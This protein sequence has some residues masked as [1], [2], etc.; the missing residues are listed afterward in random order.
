M[1]DVTIAVLRGEAEAD[2]EWKDYTVEVDEGQ[3]VLDVIHRI[4]AT[5][6][7]DL[8]VRWN[9]KGGKCLFCQAEVDGQAIVGSRGIGDDYK[10]QVNINSYL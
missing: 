8:A 1:P 7:P 3:V 9:C 5:E 4:Q 10:R 6:A 2:S